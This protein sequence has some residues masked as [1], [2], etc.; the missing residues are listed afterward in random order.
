MN[1][2]SGHLAFIS[3]LKGPFVTFA[4]DFFGRHWLRYVSS[5]ERPELTIWLVRRVP[6]TRARYF[7]HTFAKLLAK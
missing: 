1:T 7:C 3:E 6:G 4:E 2:N 5:S